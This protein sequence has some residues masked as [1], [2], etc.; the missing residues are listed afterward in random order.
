[1]FRPVRERVAALLLELLESHGHGPSGGHG[2]SD[3][4]Q[5]I[6]LKLSHQ[7]LANLIGA[8]RET[9]TNEI[10]RLQGEKVIVVE[11]RRIF[12]IDHH[13]LADEAGESLV[14]RPSYKTPTPAGRAH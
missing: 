14:P 7:D 2:K 9:V 3:G 5:E 8:T 4:R 10:G 11:R 13:R 1:V 6:G 12:V